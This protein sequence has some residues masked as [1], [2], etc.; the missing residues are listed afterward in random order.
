MIR[1]MQGPKK[2]DQSNQSSCIHR[3]EGQNNG[4]VRKLL[5]DREK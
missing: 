2:E 4:G 5:T 1:K 3:Y